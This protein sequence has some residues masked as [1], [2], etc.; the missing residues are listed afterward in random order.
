M[1]EA[2]VRYLLKVKDN[3]TGLVV[4]FA[5]SFEEKAC[6]KYKWGKAHSRKLR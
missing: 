1:L 3:G 5:M 6:R 4:H 2:V